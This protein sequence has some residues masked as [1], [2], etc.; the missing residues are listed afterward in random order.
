M[1]GRIVHVC[2]DC[3]TVVVW[4]QQQWHNVCWHTTNQTQ[5]NNMVNK[6]CG[7]TYLHLCV[8]P[9]PWETLKK[10]Q[11]LFILIVLSGVGEVKPG[12]RFSGSFS[13]EQDRETPFALLLSVR[14]ST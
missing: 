5:Q 9:A 4:A 14:I 12:R 2:K 8:N 7:Q 11:L 13:W 3:V 10:Q 6:C 1:S